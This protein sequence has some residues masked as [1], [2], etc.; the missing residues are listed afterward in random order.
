M[1]SAYIPENQHYA[2]T[3]A[4]SAISDFALPFEI[5]TFASFPDLSITGL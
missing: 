4:L 1:A 3:N 2:F 5:F